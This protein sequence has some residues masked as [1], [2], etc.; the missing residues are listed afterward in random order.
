M[1]PPHPQVSAM[2]AVNVP[3]K[4]AEGGL[5]MLDS[6]VQAELVQAAAGWKAVEAEEAAEKAAAAAAAQEEAGGEAEEGKEAEEAEKA[7]A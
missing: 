3:L 6:K 4:A 2:I 7:A 5:W 1:L